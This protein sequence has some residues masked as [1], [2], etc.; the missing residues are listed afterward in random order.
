MPTEGKSFTNHPGV[1]DFRGK[2]YFFYHNGALPG[3]SGFTRSVS[4]EEINFNKDGSILPI[5]MTAGITKAIASVNPYSFNQAETIAWSENV[6][7]YQNKEAGVFIKAKKNGAYTSVKNVDF[8]K[9]GAQSLSA[10]V[11]TTHNSEVTM[12]VRLDHISGPI[13][14]TIKVPLTGGDDRWETVKAELKEK[15]TGTHDLY[16]VFNGKAAQDIMYFDY[17]TFSKLK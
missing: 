1:I 10:R 5:K 14:A 13:V 15:I 16:F 7:S 3:G 17:W 12:D 9:D 4:V 2:T 6:K 8:G 11:G